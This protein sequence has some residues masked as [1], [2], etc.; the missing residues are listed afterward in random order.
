MC[1]INSTIVIN[2]HVEIRMFM[3]KYFSGYHRPTKINRYEYL[4]HEWFSHENFS[5][6]WYTCTFPSSNYDGD[7]NSPFLIASYMFLR[8]HNLNAKQV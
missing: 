8:Q 6:L 5:D 1:N 4:M 7:D 3:L 2:V